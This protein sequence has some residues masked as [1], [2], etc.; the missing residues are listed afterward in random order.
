MTSLRLAE[1]EAWTAV[2]VEPGGGRHK[3]M[4]HYFTI[5]GTVEDLKAAIERRAIQDPAW[6]RRYSGWTLFPLRI[7]R[8]IKIQ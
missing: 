2:G 4:D 1:P 7:D 3:R 6:R 5:R 8:G